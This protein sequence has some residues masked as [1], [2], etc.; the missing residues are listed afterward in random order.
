[1]SEKIP[2]I[3]L[4]P[5]VWASLHRAGPG[6]AASTIALL[7]RE[8]RNA[9]IARGIIFPLRGRAP[10]VIRLTPAGIRFLAECAAAHPE[11]PEREARA[12]AELARARQQWQEEERERK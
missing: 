4:E 1:M 9:L 6:W 10:Q 7:S 5:S 11:D 3:P 8:E 2:A 12:E